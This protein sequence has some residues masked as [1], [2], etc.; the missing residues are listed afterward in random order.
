M[1]VQQSFLALA[2]NSPSRSPIPA[3]HPL[4]M[5]LRDG[6]LVCSYQR[7][8]APPFGVRAR[9]TSALGKTGSEETVLR[10]DVPFSN[11]LAEPNTV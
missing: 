2:D 9:F 4:L 11:A 6:T 3:K 5:K 7:R 8:T 10:D 1:S